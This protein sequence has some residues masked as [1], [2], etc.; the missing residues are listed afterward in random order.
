MA[1]A[2]RINEELEKLLNEK[3][4]DLKNEECFIGHP[5]DP[6]KCLITNEQ[7]GYIKWGAIAVGALYVAKVASPVVKTAGEGFKLLTDNDNK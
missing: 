1:E 4:E 3:K 2:L 6:T 5:T 7:W